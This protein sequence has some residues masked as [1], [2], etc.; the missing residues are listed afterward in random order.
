VDTFI[1]VGPKTVLKGMMRKIAPKGYQYKA[2]QFDTPEG[3]AKCMDK[4][5]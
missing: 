2:L 3:L 5:A 4:L 1:E